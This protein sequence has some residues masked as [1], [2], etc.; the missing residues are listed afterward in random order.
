[1]PFREESSS[2]GEEKAH[3]LAYFV[4]APYDTILLHSREAG[5]EKV[6]HE[7]LANFNFR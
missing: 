1:M 4:R 2:M 6:G 5:K 3:H 7:M